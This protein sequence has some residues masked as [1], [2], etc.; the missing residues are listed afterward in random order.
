MNCSIS[1]A[2]LVGTVPK[3]FGP[4]K[5]QPRLLLLAYVG[6]VFISLPFAPDVVLAL[7]AKNLLSAAVTALYAITV[8][9]VVYHIVFDLRASDWLAYTALAVLIALIAALMLGLH[10]VEER[11][12]FVQ[13]AVM[14]LLCRHAITPSDSGRSGKRRALIGAAAM[15]SGL[16]LLDELVQHWVPRRSFDPRD[17]ALNSM[18]VVLALGLDEALHDRLELR[19]SRE[20]KQAEPPE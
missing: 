19:G 4:K 8:A 11:V 5:L 15:A 7:R 10:I 2:Q 17:V 13:Y 12:H 3:M 20:K 14:G 1:F 9:A 18:A 16:G 6:V